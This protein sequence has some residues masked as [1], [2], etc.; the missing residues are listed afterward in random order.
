MKTAILSFLFISSIFNGQNKKQI[1]YQIQKDIESCRIRIND[2]ISVYKINETLFG[3][4]IAIIIETEN[5]ITR[6]CVD[7]ISDDKLVYNLN[8]LKNP[9]ITINKN[10]I[11]GVNIKDFKSLI[12]NKILA[13][14]K[15]SYTTLVV[16]FYNFSYTTV[17][18][19]YINLCFKI[20]SK[21]NVNESKIIESKFS[22][23][24]NKLKKVF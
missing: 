18:N 16:E 22:L 4:N 13:I 9:S 2:S 20:D 17:G 14:K 12:P 24:I 5:V 10:N 19:A 1:Y 11:K 6:E 15:A 21:G 23:Q 3:N 7:Q 8:Y